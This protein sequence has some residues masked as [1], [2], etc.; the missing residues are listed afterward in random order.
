MSQ[1]LDTQDDRLNAEL[2]D[3]G[4]AAGLDGA[5]ASKTFL[6]I[7]DLGRKSRAIG[8]R[9]RAGDI[10]VALDGKP[11]RGT[12]ADFTAQISPPEEE[13][14]PTDDSEDLFLEEEP[15]NAEKPRF[16]LTIIR[17]G[18]FFEVFVEGPLGCEL[19]YVLPD[20]ARI[21]SEAFGQR[22][23]YPLNDYIGYEVY[24]DITRKCSLVDQTPSLL[25]AVAPP[26]WLLENRMLEPLLAVLSIYGLTFGINIYLFIATYILTSLYFQKGQLVFKRSYQMFEQRHMW[27]YLVATNPRDA[28]ITCRK[29]D[30]KADFEFSLIPPPRPARKPA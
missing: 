2:P 22:K 28:Q 3:A 20:E 26:L 17:N 11:F 24:R 23:I 13:E 4:D 14:I 16:L 19:D 30:P 12:P 9:L 27:I 10:I 5:L 18:V 29:L 6:R 7:K 25:A 15:Q 1:T 8:L 21:I